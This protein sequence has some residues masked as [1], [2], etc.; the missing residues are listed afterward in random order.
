[1]TI[2]RGT[3]GSRY[4]GVVPLDGESLDEVPPHLLPPVGADSDTRSSGRRRDACARRRRHPP[5]VARRRPHRPVPARSAGSHAPAAT[6]PAATHRR[7]RRQAGRQTRTT[8]GRGAA[9]VDTVAG[10]RADR[11][12]AAG[13]ESAFSPV[14]PARRPRFQAS[15]ESATNARVRARRCRRARNFSADEIA[16]SIEDGAITVTCEFCGTRY[17]F[18]PADSRRGSDSL[19]KLEHGDVAMLRKSFG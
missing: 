8:P 3:G 2:D 18:D 14:R 10:R 12:G 1:M 7:L 6:C 15:P 9:P 17:E 19:Q 16:E 11:S 13:R 5:F 4:Q